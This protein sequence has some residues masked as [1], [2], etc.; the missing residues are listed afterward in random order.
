[1]GMAGVS[2]TRG[3]G[4]G[5]VRAGTG[6][7]Q[8]ARSNTGAGAGACSRV[9]SIKQ[10]LFT[11]HSVEY[12][13]G[14]KIRMLGVIAA[15]A[16]SSEQRE[17]E[18][19]ARHTTQTAAEAAEAMVRAKREA[20]ESSSIQELEATHQRAADSCRLLWLA[21]ANKGVYIK[22]AQHLS[23]FESGRLHTNAARMPG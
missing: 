14:L 9:E 5:R 2:S 19:E 12:L 18:K 1:M 20:Q 13:W 3:V 8:S 4:A 22:L 21:R 6:S 23:Q 11:V 17:A 10:L 15:N 16:P 7:R